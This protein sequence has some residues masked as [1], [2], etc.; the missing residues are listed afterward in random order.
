MPKEVEGEAVEV[1]SW[2]PER[3]LIEAEAALKPEEAELKPEEAELILGAAEVVPPETTMKATEEAL[4]L[5]TGEVGVEVPG[6]LTV[7][8]NKRTAFETWAALAASSL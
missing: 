1:G 7:P 4:A 5:K 2:A 3:G 6:A 8:K